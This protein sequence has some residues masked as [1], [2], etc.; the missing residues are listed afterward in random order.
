MCIS[1]SPFWAVRLSCPPYRNPKNHLTNLPKSR[2]SKKKK[3][4]KITVDSS[5]SNPGSFP[6]PIAT[7]LIGLGS[8]W[9]M[10]IILVGNE[11]ALKNPKDAWTVRPE[12]MKYS[13]DQTRGFSEILHIRFWCLCVSAELMGLENSISGHKKIQQFIPARKFWILDKLWETSIGP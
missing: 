11:H 4:W 7:V 1:A 5:I 8:D 2:I 13:L 9:L 6:M 3:S 10:K 12:S